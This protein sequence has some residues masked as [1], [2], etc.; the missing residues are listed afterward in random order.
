MSNSSTGRKAL[1]Q[2]GD[3]VYLKSGGPEMSVFDIQKYGGAFTGNYTCQWF[4]GKKLEKG[5]FAEESL[6]NTNPKP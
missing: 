4:A 2:L 1:Y 5:I 3:S 6:T